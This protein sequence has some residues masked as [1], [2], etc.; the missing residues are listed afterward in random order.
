MSIGKQ[1]RAPS[2]VRSQKAEGKDGG[3]ERSP[4]ATILAGRGTMWWV[5]NRTEW[6]RFL[7]IYSAEFLSCDWSVTTRL[8]SAHGAVIS[9][10]ARRAV[11]MGFEPASVA[12][13][14]SAEDRLGRRLPPSLR[15]FYQV[16]NGWGMIGSSIYNVL[17]V[18]KIGWLKDRDPRFHR[19][20]CENEDDDWL[21]QGRWVM[22]SLAISSWGDAAIWLLDPGPRP[23]K[24]EWRGGIWASW[25]PGMEWTAKSFE[26]LMRRE[27]KKN[28]THKLEAR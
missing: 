25:I 23:K 21:D 19:M 4:F 10:K 11:W 6:R 5:M 28:R 1:P 7:K 24:G 14:R 22:R 27:L 17:P 13:I 8:F 15:T 20:I 16:S 2:G 26:Q 3:G 12:A 9:D 18:E